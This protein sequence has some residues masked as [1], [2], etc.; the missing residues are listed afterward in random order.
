MDALVEPS[1]EDDLLEASWR[2]YHAEITA[3]QRDIHLLRNETARR[4]GQLGMYEL[5]KDPSSHY[6][7]FGWLRQQTRTLEIRLQDVLLCAIREC[8]QERAERAQAIRKF[9]DGQAAKISPHPSLLPLG[10]GIEKLPLPAG[11]D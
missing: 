2:R 7:V 10:E 5:Q 11:E 6:A 3:V 1:L 4:L 9:C 8:A